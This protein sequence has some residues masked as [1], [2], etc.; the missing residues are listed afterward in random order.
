MIAHLRG[1]LIRNPPA[2]RQRTFHPSC[3]LLPRRTILEDTLLK[4]G[5]KQHTRRWFLA[6]VAALGRGALFAAEP[7]AANLRIEDAYSPRDARRATRPRTEYIILHT[8]EADDSSSFNSVYR[9]GTCHYLILTDGLVRRII[10]RDKIANHAGR[11][12]W[13]GVR[14][15][16]TRSLGIEIVGTYL[17]PPT[18]AQLAALKQVL[19]ELQSLYGIPD[20]NV[21][22]HSQI[23]YSYNSGERRMVRG[24]R[25]DAVHFADPEIRARIGLTDRWTYDPDERAGRVA[26]QNYPEGRWL[27]DVLYAPEASTEPAK[28]PAP[29]PT[30]AAL[31]QADAA[32]AEA[33]GTEAADDST[34][35]DNTADDNIANDNSADPETFEGFLVLGVHG[36]TIEELAGAG[37]LSPTTIYFLPDGRM[38][39][40][41]RLRG[42]PL[43]QHPP[44]GLKIL[45]GYVVGGEVTAK[46]HAIDI[47]GAAWNYPSTFYRL[48]DHSIRQGDKIDESAIPP[49]TVILYRQ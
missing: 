41:D 28:P 24:R 12:L 32:K 10:H 3:V 38:R 36:D 42:S 14:N 47:A 15:L 17:D 1:T 20:K 21:L 22:T 4:T 30:L 31:G 13:N 45:M 8:T 23:A 34:A 25:K 27:R 37:A 44:E 26:F 9:Y 43:L 6:S 16:S 2:R 39:S 49:G 7:G 33:T 48:P 40:G 11:S 18:K 5:M 29:L 46:R 19:A 35:D